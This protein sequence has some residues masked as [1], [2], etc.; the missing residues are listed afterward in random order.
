MKSLATFVPAATSF[1]LLLALPAAL[2]ADPITVLAPIVSGSV[3]DQPV[4]GIGDTVRSDTLVLRADR[5]GFAMN[6]FSAILEYRLDSLADARLTSARI[7]GT[8][9]G[10]NFLDTGPRDIGLSLFS[11]DG[12][13]GVDDF[14]IPAQR[15][16][17]VE[18]RPTGTHQ[19]VAFSFPIR[20]AL[21]GLIDTGARFA[22][23][24]FDALNFQAS[25]VVVE[26]FTNA[27]P[28]LTVDTTPT[29]E[30]ASLLLMGSA[31]AIVGVR[32]RSRT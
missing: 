13:L 12:R 15:I 30:P 32:R 31:L 3:N 6:V 28:V 10:N 18:Y 4:D 7:T 22:G 25:S 9:L 17:M 1:V 24:R 27:L 29:P 8:I 11:G 16:G 23:I 26:P 14:T 19:S 5:Q 21:Q 20:P 2:R